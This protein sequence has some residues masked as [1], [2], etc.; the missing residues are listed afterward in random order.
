MNIFKRLA[1]LGKR[2]KELT[3]DQIANLIDGGGGW[4]I[5]GV[6]VNERTALEVSTVLDCVTV[7]ADGCSTPELHVMRDIGGGRSE[8]ASNIPEYRLLTKRPNEWQTASEWRWMMTAQAV[9]GGGGLSIKVKGDNGRL[10]ELIPLPLGAW[11]IERTGR[12]DWQVRCW[13]EYGPIGTYSLDEVFYLPGRQMQLGRLLKPVH[14]AARAIGLALATEK[15]YASMHANGLQSSGMY[16]IKEALDENQH[17]KLMGWIA[18]HTGAANAG[19]PLILDRDAKWTPL[20]MSSVEAE[21]DKTRSRQIE[22]VCRVFNVF[23]IMVGHSDKTFA[24]AS[25]EA[26]FAAH[27]KHTLA[28]WHK[29]WLDRL[30]EFALD[31]SGPLF[32]K[33][34]TRYLT[35]GSTRDRAQLLRTLAELGIY[36]RNELREEEGRDPLPGLDEPLTPLNMTRSTQDNNGDPT[37]ETAPPN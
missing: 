15:T 5:A 2:A 8:R 22:E 25:A 3:Y 33:F 18:K 26:F 16:S 13:D 31:G 9:L 32:A 21:G 30:D 6:H 11:K 24:F 19:K 28:P 1:T 4:E 10:R 23:P 36:T 29:R 17:N 7:I 27:L 12:Y 37:D 20:R 35:A 14:L 34:D